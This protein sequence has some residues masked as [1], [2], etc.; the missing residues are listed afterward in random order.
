[1]V[2]RKMPPGTAGRIGKQPCR[3]RPRCPDA[4]APDRSAVRTVVNHPGQGWSLLCNG[5]VRFDDGGHCSLT[6]E[7]SPPQSL[8][9]CPGPHEPA[10][11]SS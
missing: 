1:M 6:A 5:M 11:T 4:F 7:P 8:A 9:R 2:E 3:H 10:R